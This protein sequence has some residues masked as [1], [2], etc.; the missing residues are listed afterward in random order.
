MKAGDRQLVTAKD[1]ILLSI[2]DAGTFV[3]TLNGLAGR[4]LGAPGEVVS[5][6]ITSTT[7]SQ[8]VAP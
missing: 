4:P 8:F 5:A 7:L 2:G 3:Y 6:R 1:Q